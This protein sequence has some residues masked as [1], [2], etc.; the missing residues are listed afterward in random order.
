MSYNFTSK[1]DTLE[2]LSKNITKSKIEPLIS[3]TINDWKHDKSKILEKLCKQFKKQ[4]VVVR[5]SA[6]GEDTIETSNAGVF[7][8]ILNVMP[9]RNTLQKSIDHVINSYHKKKHFNLN[10]QVIVQR[11]STCIK[12]SGVIFTRI[13][14]TGA[15]YYIINYEDGKNT[16][17]V[18]KGLIGN[19]VKISRS[20]SMTKIPTKWRKLLYAIKEIELILENNSIDIEFGIT[21]NSIIIFQARP[22]TTITQK[23][24]R[25]L[26]KK[27]LKIIEKNQNEY[28]SYS[29][30]SNSNTRIFSD[31][32]DWNPS[33]IIGN[34]PNLLDYSLYDY[35]IM[36]RSW[37]E[38]RNLLDYQTI[39]DSKLMKRFGNKPYVDVNL[40]FDSLIP[41]N[42]NK[43]TRKKLLKFY[44]DKLSSNPFL[45]DKVEFQIL[46]TCSDPSLNS[47]MREL[48]KYSFSNE[49]IIQI[50][51]SLTE[52]TN[53][54]LKKT[55]GL[56]L[57][58]D[59][60][61][62]I[63]RKNRIKHIR[64]LNKSK[65]NHNDYLELSQKLLED[66]K[67]YGVIPFSAVARLAFI[68]VTILNGLE[69]E[70]IL[71]RTS[72][73]N[74][75]SQIETPMSDYKN[76]LNL[77]IDKKIS[78]KKFLEKYGHLRPGTYDI[79][80]PRYDMNSNY[81]SNTKFFSQKPIPITKNL[82]RKINNRLKKSGL[83]F[84]EISFID[85]VKKSIIQRE[86]LKFEFTKNLS[87]SLEYIATAGE[88]LGFSR[89]EISH[90][91]IKKI[92]KHN[93]KSKSQIKKF[94]RYNINKNRIRISENNHLHLPSI[95]FSKND[96][97]IIN[98][99][100]AKP[101]FI[102]SKQ[103]SNEITFLNPKTKSQTLTNKI[104][105]I[106]NA[107]PGYDWIFTKN[108]SGL[109]TKYGGMAS[110][111]A[112]RCAEI[113]IPAA[114]GC[115]ELLFQ[116]LKIS[117]QVFL[118]CKNQQIS[119]QKYRKNDKFLEEKRILKSL[120]YIK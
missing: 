108:P 16:D 103:I 13:P 42:I 10:N 3:F 63:L 96:F 105:I 15:P 58:F 62:E 1:S 99:F 75:L 48:K 117:E 54:L 59:K 32:A 30:N 98:E 53:K 114:I 118:D 50:K 43:K 60:S 28:E 74:L 5:S 72:S 88:K 92:L 2:Y 84:N 66:C 87:D 7:T 40:S 45:H 110:H 97:E 61:F 12:T 73:D 101:N 115:G 38:G 21:D 22:L 14:D 47:R 106:E 68:A 36:S 85:F 90:L 116:K 57:D 33:E 93:K 19:S 23:N 52:F 94:W 69:S 104:V 102:T 17:S 51:K 65:K 56:F 95:I 11:Q 27:I 86:K 18:T 24:Y 8:S 113:G 4:K 25:I 111:M 44:L 71:T 35:L 31:M 55:P 6:L 79:T 49:E 109:I 107:D 39:P 83:V 70:S 81:L 77:L 67:K 120:G 34:N 20:T 37:Y 82:E 26:E 29:K 64:E 76:E 91:E 119:I 46:F 78:K 112:I 100:F 9:S 80:V 89:E 41:N